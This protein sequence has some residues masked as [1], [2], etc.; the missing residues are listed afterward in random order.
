MSAD[1]QENATGS[2]QEWLRHAQSDLALGKVGRESDEVL[3]EQICFHAQQAIEKCIKAILIHRG[4]SVPKSHDIEILLDLLR[5][6]ECELPS[7]TDELPEVNP[8]AVEARYPGDWDEIRPGDRDRALGLAAQTV[9]W[10]RETIGEA[11][12]PEDA[13]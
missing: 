12:K 1:R 4:S 7:W 10:T 11:P 3:P 8:Y 9:E 6:G 2:P 13:E 5:Q